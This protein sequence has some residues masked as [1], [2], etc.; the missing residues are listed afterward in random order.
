MTQREAE[1]FRSKLQRLIFCKAAGTTPEREVADWVATLDQRTALKLAQWELISKRADVISPRLAEFLDRYFE[2]RVDV[3]PATQTVYRRV[4]RHLVTFFGAEKL[5]T[6]INPG[7]AD[8]WEMYLQANGL[9]ENTVRRH[10]GCARQFFK[11][12]VRHKIITEN[13]FQDLKAGVTANPERFYFLTADDTQ[14]LMD[15]CPPGPFGVEWRLIIALARFGGL[16]TPSETFALTWQNVDWEN[17]RITVLSPKTEHHVGHASRVIPIFPELRP[18][19]DAAWFEAEKGEGIIY[20]ITSYR[21]AKQNLRT[22]FE[23][24]IQKAGLNPWPKLFQNLRSS[25]ETELAEKFPIQV[26]VAWM[27]NSEPVAK[28]HYLQVT[29]DHFSKALNEPCSALQKALQQVPESSRSD[30]QSKSD[31]FPDCESLQDV[32]ECREAV[33][34]CTVGGTGLEPVTPSV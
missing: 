2:K 12:A 23:R 1:S 3:K 31:V 5:I 17:S 27:G 7:D 13:P 15:A 21:D 29:E 22:Q 32:A 19:L 8:D 6:E 24:I 9:A 25:R 33:Q 26:V 16:R 28:K 4:R 18:Y 11:V 30:S 14:R 20:P 34:Y 10:I